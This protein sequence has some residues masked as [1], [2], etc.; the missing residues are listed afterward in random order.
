MNS[1]TNRYMPPHNPCN[2]CQYFNM[3]VDEKPVEGH[4]YMFREEPTE[5]CHTFKLDHW[6]LMRD[7]ARQIQEQSNG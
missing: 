7:I 2:V 4:C 6:Q 3:T 5:R 1:M